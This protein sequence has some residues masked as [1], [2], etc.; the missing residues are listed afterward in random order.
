MLKTHSRELDALLQMAD[1]LVSAG[2]F[3]ALL[4][5]PGLRTGGDEGGLVPLALAATL[6]LALLLRLLDLYTSQRRAHLGRILQQMALAGGLAVLAEGAVAHASAAPVVP[7][8]PL[9]CGGIQMLAL[10][11]CRTLLHSGLRS[12]RRRGRNRRHVLIVG[13]GPRAAYVAEVLEANPSWGLDLVGFID[14]GAPPGGP[15]V[16]RERLFA[17]EHIQELLRDQVLDEVIVACPRSKLADAVE[18]VDAASEA[19]VPIT[20]LS[21]LFGDALPP[22]RPTRFGALPA[23]AFAPVHHPRIGL[24]AKRL[25]DVGAAALG[26]VLTAPI[27]AAAALAIKLNSPGPVLFRQI[28]CT[29]NGRPFVMPKLRTMVADAERQ[30]ETLAAANEMDGPVFKM[31]ADPRIT[32][33]G[34]FLRRTSLDE[35][36]QLWSVLVGHMSLVGPRPPTPVEVAAYRTWE[37]R[38]LSMRPGL[39][40]IW[41]VTGRNRIGFEDWVRLDLQ[42][43]DTWSLGQDLRIL[44]RTVPAVLSGQGAS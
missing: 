14:R 38:R 20:L 16:P 8:F 32:R 37:R 9:V 11:A 18:V 34:R 36:P 4:A 17:L 35:L 40:C 29:R 24:A 28:R 30:K 19:G 42:Y 23:L 27:L 7:A 21:D 25:L 22:P 13:S 10:A 41:Q 1:L 43:I 26:L 39:T 15:C 44:L 12:L 33:V 31:R 2:V 3:L 6:S 5:V